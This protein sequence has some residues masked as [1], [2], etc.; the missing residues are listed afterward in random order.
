MPKFILAVFATLPAL[1]GW[2]PACEAQDRQPHQVGIVNHANGIVQEIY[3]APGD[4]ADWGGNR[5]ISRLPGGAY[6]SIRF[7]GPCAAR[8]RIVLNTGQEEIHNADLCQQSDFS[9]TDRELTDSTD[10]VMPVASRAIA[11]QPTP[12]PEPDVPGAIDS[13]RWNGRFLLHRYGGL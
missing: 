4:T 5:L 13:N 8:L 3:I 6:A 2:A 11:R 9:V 12:T 1:C 10:A 7:T